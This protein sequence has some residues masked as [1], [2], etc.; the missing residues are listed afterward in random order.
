MARN[1]AESMRDRAFAKGRNA[2]GS[3]AEYRAA[4]RGELDDPGGATKEERQKD[5]AYELALEVLQPAGEGELEDIEWYAAA[6]MS[7]AM[8][9][10]DPYF[11]EDGE[12]GET[13]QLSRLPGGRVRL[14]SYGDG[15]TVDIGIEALAHAVEEL[16]REDAEK[17]V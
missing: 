9:P 5:R 8:T 3:D 7:D 12:G 11:V 1:S 16:S 10:D 13:F 6:S 4:L 2:F 14:E 17:S 15:R